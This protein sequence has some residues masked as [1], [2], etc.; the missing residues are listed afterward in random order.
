MFAATEAFGCSVTSKDGGNEE[1]EEASEGRAVT[2]SDPDPAVLRATSVV[3]AMN[4]GRLCLCD[5]EV[6]AGAAAASRAVADFAAPSS[7]LGL[8]E[9]APMKDMFAGI[10]ANAARVRL[11]NGCT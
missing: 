1:V 7:V 11:D 5:F 2:G 8:F 6:T 3:S 9:D 10:E 4:L